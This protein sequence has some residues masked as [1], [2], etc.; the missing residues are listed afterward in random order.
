MI[1]R[2]Y[3]YTRVVLDGRSTHLF[4]NTLNFSYSAPPLH[5][6]TFPRG[7]QKF[8]NNGRNW[9]RQPSNDQLFS[10][11]FG[12][13]NWTPRTLIT[14]A[15]QPVP[16]SIRIDTFQ[17]SDY[18]VFFSVGH[19]KNQFLWLGGDYNFGFRFLKIPHCV[20]GLRDDI[21]SFWFL[22]FMRAG[23]S[24]KTT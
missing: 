18:G 15:T 16:L 9:P 4:P 22:L 21:R 2:T 20:Y 6:H 23:R 11:T 12:K 8:R 24:R 19:R 14:S 17:M 10:R 7:K 13:N 1:P 5:L 3:S